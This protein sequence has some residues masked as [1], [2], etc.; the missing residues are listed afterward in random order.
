VDADLGAVPHLVVAARREAVAA[1][2]H[3]AL[4]VALPPAVRAD[5]AW[6]ARAAA[7]DVRLVP[8][9]H[10]VVARR[11][12]VRLGR[13]PG[14]GPGVDLGDPHVRGAAAQGEQDPRRSEPAPLLHRT[15]LEL[16]SK[17]TARSARAGPTR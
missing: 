5:A 10:A 7:V 15:R 17:G 9:A 16:R 3:P 1:R 4:A 12:R 11:P 14:V 8:V 6:L 2:A 13:R